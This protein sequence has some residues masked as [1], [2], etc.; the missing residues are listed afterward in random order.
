MNNSFYITTPIYYP[1]GKPHLGHAYCTLACDALARFNRLE[2]KNV[3]FATGTDEH[4]Q[5]IQQKA[6]ELKITP[7]EYVDN[8][9]KDFKT[10]TP[11]MN[12]SNDDFISTTEE[13]HKKAAQ[14]MWKRLE[15]AG[16]IY[17]STYSGWY[18]VS[19]EAYFTEEELVDGKSP[20][21]GNPVEWMEEDSYF[22]KLSAFTDKLLE[23]YEQNPDFIQPE[24]RRNEIISFVKQGLQDISISRSKFNWGVPVPG[25]EKHVM[26]VWI[27]ALTNYLTVAGFP[28]KDITE[29]WP[30]NAHVVGKDIARFHCI[31][32][33]AMLMA[34]DIPT[35]KTVFVHGHW[36]AEDGRKMSKS[37]GNV[38]DPY[39]V[40][41]QFGQDQLRLYLLSAITFGG[42]GSFSK[43]AFI[44][45]SNS[46]LANDLG[47][48]FQRVLS[49]AHKNFDGKIPVLGELTD[50]DKEFLANFEGLADR[51]KAQMDDYKINSAIEEIW[52]CVR[53]ANKY[54]EEQ[55]PWTY[56]KEDPAKCGHILRV[57]MESFKFLACLTEPFIPTGAAKLANQLGYEKLTLA[58]LN[59]L[60][61]LQEGKE[62][63]K[64]EGVFARIQIEEA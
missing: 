60:I 8:M 30:A 45:K 38:I 15:K 6:D 64:P 52:T 61:S 18:C 36:V 46:Y 43:D 16:Y 28:E 56:K 1:S 29:F 48:L 22:F 3:L 17:K 31:Y 40:V 5:K 25:D 58:D 39:E 27:D 7:Q 54:M 57:L 51:V 50:E 23:F 32:W 41:E 63:D 53:A 11:L 47:N 4:G 59:E 9:R 13:R 12:F 62:F 37:L 42:D 2:G 20:D 55:H 35:P 19:D 33:P 24:I 26:Y 44:A 49:F 14:E 34:A 21:S 10:L